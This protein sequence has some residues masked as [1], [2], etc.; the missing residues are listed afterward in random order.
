MKKYGNRTANQ[1][2]ARW[3]HG[4]QERQ[5]RQIFTPIA[6][7]ISLSGIAATPSLAQAARFDLIKL[8]ASCAGLAIECET[9]ATRAILLLQAERLPPEQL[10]TQLGI[11]ASGII[12]A[13]QASPGP[14]VVQKLAAALRRTAAASTDATQ[15]ASILEVAQEVASGNAGR[16]DIITAFSASPA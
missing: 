4:I 1:V 3:P 12:A 15:T 8:K 5:M 16:I 10:N 6:L 9:A 7:A 14:D 2:D 13:A 11:I